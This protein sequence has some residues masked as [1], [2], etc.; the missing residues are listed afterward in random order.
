MASTRCPQLCV[1]V[2]LVALAH[3]P[4]LQ[5]HTSAQ[6]P[7][8]DGTP[9]AQVHSDDGGFG[10]SFRFDAK[11][12]DLGA[13]L[14]AFKAQVGRNWMVPQEAYFIHGRVSLT[15]VIERGGAL[16]ELQVAEPSTVHRFT[17][18]AYNALSASNPTVPLPPAYPDEVLRMRV[19]FFYN[20]D[21]SGAPTV[22]SPEVLPDRRVAFRVYAPTAS[23]V[24]VAG[25]WLTGSVP[26]ALTRDPEGGTWSASTDPLK[27]DLYRYA[28]SVDGVRMHNRNSAHAKPD[29]G[30][31]VEDL[32]FVPGAEA[33][34][35]EAR[36]VPHGTV[37]Q[38][39]Y[40]PA[41][42]GA[43]RL[44]DI[45]MPPGYDRNT[46]EYP[47]LYLLNDDMAEQSGWNAFG[48]AAVILDNL[49]ADK[50]AVPMIVVMPT[51]FPRA[52]DRPMPT[53]DPPRDRG[54]A[55]TNTA[56]F[57]NEL[58]QELIPFVEKW[59]RAGRRSSMRAIAGLS[60]GGEQAL[61]VITTH[62]DQFEYVSI[63][64]AGLS[65]TMTPAFETRAAGFLSN[66]TQVNK[67]LKLLS[68]A[69]GERD[70][71]LE[72]SRNLSAVLRKHGI[73]HE[74]LISDSGHTWSGGRRYLNEL[75]QRLFSG[76][77]A[78]ASR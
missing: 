13:W 4:Q 54:E 68:I 75:A 11:G 16:S 66:A 21:P 33:A 34:F 57:G 60:D 43:T 70:P 71:A 31:T 32:F 2:L 55:T 73:K 58:I 78:P 28:F 7:N 48:R 72:A 6:Q 27:P 41:T 44:V 25:D 65:A 51:A 64:N 67:R 19:T 45:Y 40:R 63:W 22:T 20:E 29:G 36:A 76:R 24:A 77:A 1:V 8:R 47:V 30:P 3:G 37:K 42:G 56:A 9:R 39:W 50:R 10:Q 12:A 52:V 35:L 74:L 46:S 61:S 23:H 26:L 15:L 18:A 59:Y 69:V 14:R 49:L 17:Q 53:L 62:P 5:A 38:T